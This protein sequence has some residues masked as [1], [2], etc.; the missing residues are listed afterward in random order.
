M[1]VGKVLP[2]SASNDHKGSR[3]ASAVFLGIAVVGAARSLIHLLAPDGGAGSIAGMDLKVAGAQSIIFA[4]SL[5]GISQI[6]MAVVQFIVYFRYRNLIPLMYLLLIAEYSL[7]VVVG[8]IKPVSFTHTPPGQIG[9]Y[10]M[11]P[12]AAVMFFLAVR[13]RRTQP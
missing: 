1:T 7:R 6:L 8:H 9:N 4:F 3:L 12:L 13:D 10:A 5:W 11:V 2:K